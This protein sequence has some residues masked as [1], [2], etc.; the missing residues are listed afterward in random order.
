MWRSWR[1]RWQWKRSARASDE[2]IAVIRAMLFG[3]DHRLAQLYRQ[4]EQ[5]AW[6]ERVRI[7]PSVYQ[8][9]LVWTADDPQFPL[10]SSVESR[11][12]VTE[13]RRS[14]RALEF[15]L[16]IME[17]GF[18]GE[19]QGTALDGLPWPKEFELPTSF[20][21][22]YAGQ[23]YLV[24][25]PAQGTGSLLRLLEWAGVPMEEF[26]SSVLVR[27]RPGA[28]DRDVFELSRMEG[29]D[30]SAELVEFFLVSDGLELGT[31]NILGT[32]DAYRLDASPIKGAYLVLAD[33]REEGIL[34]TASSMMPSTPVW[35]VP[36]GAKAIGSQEEIAP[37]F[38]RF[39]YDRVCV[40]R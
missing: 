29:V 10:Y 14:G 26:S 20:T 23:A 7:K 1:R 11:P 12:L 31:V 6:I 3:T 30:L 22:M 25:P 34:V 38:R 32:K 16:F 18:F 24:L 33:L 28:S 37:S 13:D 35:H 8:M 9:K 39:I 36:L 2:E 40:A 19:L 4:V 15:R 27:L 5:A 17:G 21:E